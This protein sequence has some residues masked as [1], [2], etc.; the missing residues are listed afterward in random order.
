MLAQNGAGGDLFSLAERRLSWIDQ[1]QRVLAQNIANADTPGYRPRD[2]PDFASTLARANLAPART[3]PLHLA[4]V[5]SSAAGAPTSP[6]QAS[7]DGN[8]VNIE[9]ELTKVADDESSQALTT[10]L[11]KS[12]MGMFTTALDR[13]G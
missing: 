8:E 1:R 11:W 10:N 13:Q 4:A 6:A 2:I 3:S 5:V 7:P 9:T 12:W